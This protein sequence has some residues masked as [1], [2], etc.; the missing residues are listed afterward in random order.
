MSERRTTI[1]GA[2]LTAIGPISMAIYTPAM[3]ELVH[4]FATTEAA[5]KMSL[6]LYFAGF[7]LAQLVAGPVSDAFG[8]KSA[9]LSFLAIYL[10]GSLIAVLAP[11]VEWILAGRLIQGIGA[12]VGITVSRAIVRDQFTGAEAARIMNTMG[13]ILAIG[14]AAGPTIGGLSLAAFGW[15]SVFLLMVGFGAILIFISTACLRETTVPDRSR[16]QPARLLRAYAEISTVPRFLCTSLVLG[17]CVGALY[18]QA[19]VLPFILIDQVGLT[20][21]E[22]GMG[23]LMQSGFFMIGSACLRLVSKWLPAHRAPALGLLFSGGGG[24]VMALCVYFLPPSF[25]SIMGPVAICTF[26]TAF[27]TPYIITAGLAPFPHIA[28]SASALMGFI[29]MGAG[30]VGGV[31]AASIGTPLHAF[32][33]VIPTM[34]ILAVL[35]YLGYLAT[36]RKE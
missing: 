23:M 18:A 6:S 7:A 24:I 36:S 19:A 11:T 29:Q 34:H 27:V 2:L 4:A 30:F 35:G 10:A 26:G 1:I 8:R 14:P 33:I 3:P 5:I 28:G 32:G 15:K 20:P 9:S 25:L 17:G 22:Y 16:L 12:S 31:V 13:I 21:T